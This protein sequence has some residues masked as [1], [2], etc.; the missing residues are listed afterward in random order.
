MS[1]ARLYK[2]RMVGLATEKE[3]TL[4]SLQELGCL[5]LVPTR[6]G[7]DTPV[8]GALRHVHEAV[9]FLLSCP[10]RRNQVQ[11]ES[12]FD[13]ERVQADAL[14]LQLRIQTLEDDRDAVIQRIRD[15]APWGD[16]TFPPLEALGGLRLW[17]YAQPHKAMP[18]FAAAHRQWTVVN[19]DAKN[20]YVVVVSDIEPPA[21]PLPRVHSGSRSPAALRKR[22]EE[23]QQHIEDAHEQRYSLT[24]WCDLFVRHLHRLEDKAAR[25]EAGRQMLDV[26][27]LFGVEA[28]VPRDRLKDVQACAARRGLTL[29]VLEPTAAD[30]PPTLM[31][32]PRGLDAGEALVNFYMTPGYW[33]WDPSPAVLFSFAVFFAMILADAGYAALLGVLLVLSWRRTGKSA[34]GRR[35]RTLL[36]LLTGSSLIYGVMVGSYFGVAPAE[37]SLPG[38]LA[39]LDVNN[40]KVM[41][42]LS[43][44]IGVLHLMMA[45]VMNALRFGL[46]PEAIAPL[47]WT[48]VILGGFLVPVAGAM[49]LPAMRVAGLILLTAGGLGILLFSGVGKKPLPRLGNGLLALTKVTSAFGDVLSYLRLFALGLASASLAVAF[50]HMAGQIRVGVPGVGLFLAML[51]LLIGHGLNLVL[52]LS[53]AVIHGLRL[54]VIEFFNWGLPEEGRPFNTF[55]RKEQIAWNR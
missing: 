34:S 46:R 32:N 26:D 25:D 7:V 2:L 3:A 9:A 55:A 52:S 35:M 43:V 44:V 19:R 50:N 51:V 8:S 38:Q 48:A 14:A 4:N 6:V 5:M 42:A 39:F 30:D 47:G 18:E 11:D 31:K 27:P 17:F 24:R 40:A 1:I 10:R 49:Q 45:N 37:D 54:N 23:L 36:A 33:T 21:G 53:S 16:F 41:M 20:C 12:G 15:L 13:A 28:W 22:L 29:E